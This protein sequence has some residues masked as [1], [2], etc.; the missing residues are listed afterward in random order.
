MPDPTE[1]SFAGFVTPQYTPTPD[2]VFDELLAPGRLSDPA[3]RVLLYL[4]RRTFGFKKTADT[5]SL[6]Q[7]VRGITTKDGQRLDWGAGVCKASACKAI[8]E[9]VAKGIITAQHNSSRQRG[10]EAT[11]YALRMAG[12]PAPAP[13]PVSTVQTRGS[14]Q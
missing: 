6:S 3:L 9:L 1:Y 7:I 13:A 12:S 8:K 5:V 2:Q 10:D 4:I 11:T 14:M